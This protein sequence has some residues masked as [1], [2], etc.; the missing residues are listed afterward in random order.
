MMNNEITHISE[1]KNKNKNENENALENA[2]ETELETL[3]PTLALTDDSNIVH[4]KDFY[5]KKVWFSRPRKNDPDAVKKLGRIRSWVFHPKDLCCVGFLVKRP[6]VALMFHRQDTFVA[7]NGFDIYDGDI[8]I[9]DTP[10]STDRSACKALGINLDNCVL[11]IGLPVLTRDGT[12]LGIVGSV[13]Y[14]RESGRIISLE[15]DNG[16]TANTLL[17]HLNIPAEQIVGFRRGKG[18]QLYLTD[19]NDPES[20]GAIM[21]EDAARSLN[22]EGGIAEKAGSA[23]AVVADKAK[24]SAEKVKPKV[25]KATKAAGE[26]VNKG[27]YVTGRQ[28]ARTSGMFGK[29]KDNFKSAMNGED[30]DE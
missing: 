17:G 8:V 29:F 3:D 18:A 23:T 14:D 21:V 16:A 25:K 19:D 27:A 1:N 5:N 12:S 4:T 24:K 7:F 20:L 11:W 15:V 10:G 22:V 26:A 6:D 30:D 2:I 9:K 28:I 13:N